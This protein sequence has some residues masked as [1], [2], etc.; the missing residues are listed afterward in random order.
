M[1]T[2]YVFLAEGFEEIE[3]IS[4]IDILRRAGI[5]TMIISV[6]ESKVVSGAHGIPVVADNLFEETDFADAEML[7]LPGGMPGAAGLDA[8]TGLR[9]LILKFAEAGKPLAAI[10]AA[11]MVYGKLGL[12]K[13][14]KVTCYPGF[15]KFLEGA[16]LTDEAVVRDGSLITGHGPGVASLFALEIVNFFLGKAKVDELI[17]SMFI[18][19]L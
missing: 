7:V 13:G 17:K 5:H 3:A 14:K 12:L 9:S 8:H 16:L 1:G 15:E 18:T 19:L 4:V 2:I 6:I 11:P 10:C